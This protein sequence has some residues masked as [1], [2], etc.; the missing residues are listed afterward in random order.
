VRVDLGGAAA[1]GAL[2]E[3]DAVQGIENVHGGSGDD[4]LVGDDASNV[5]DDEGGRNEVDARGGDDLVRSGEGPVACGGG[6]DEVHGVKGR[7]R[8]DPDCELVFK[9]RFGETFVAHAYPQPTTDGFALRFYCPDDEDGEDVPC[10]GTVTLREAGARHRLLARAIVPVG[11]HHRTARLTLTRAG[12]RL[13]LRGAR[14][15]VL[16]L[17]GPGMVKLSWGIVVPRRT[18]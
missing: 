10:S 13:L 7:A 18:A 1:D 9:R 16:R 2:G 6:R 8:L 14:A 4:V 11:V 5:F 3:G 17:R 12:R 15:A